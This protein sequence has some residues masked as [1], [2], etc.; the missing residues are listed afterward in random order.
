MEDLSKCN[1]GEWIDV[2]DSVPNEVNGYLNKNVLC[3]FQR[4]S[5]SPVYTQEI[6]RYNGRKFFGETD[7]VIVLRWKPI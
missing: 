2:N 1:S 5:M 7:W 3:E 4:G 6:S